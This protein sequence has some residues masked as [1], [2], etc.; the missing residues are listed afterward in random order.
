MRRTTFLAAMILALALAGGCS[1]NYGQNDN[2][3]DFVSAYDMEA[4][5]P[6]SDKH[7]LGDIYSDP[8]MKEQILPLWQALSDEEVQALMDRTRSNASLP[9]VQTERKVNIGGEAGY[10]GVA[11]AEFKGAGIKKYSIKLN[12]PSV[13]VM[14]LSILAGDILP[15]V[16]RDYPVLFKSGTTIYVVNKLLSVD[17]LEYTF[18]DSKDGKVDIGLDPDLV[19]KL[20]ARIGAD[21]TNVEQGVLTVTKPR[22]I[23]YRMA[24]VTP[25]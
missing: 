18:Y 6:I 2:L 25:K 21:G 24:K 23:G 15:K 7:Y 17:S 1:K 5:S 9:D 11:E 10:L 22:F 3:A 12:N 20:T 4:I 13:Y 19:K 16:Y 14:P 8:D